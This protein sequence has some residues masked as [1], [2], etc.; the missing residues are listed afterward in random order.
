MWLT[1]WMYNGTVVM[2][3]GVKRGLLVPSV[4]WNEN[5]VSGKTEN[6]CKWWIPFAACLP[7]PSSCSL[8]WPRCRPYSLLWEMEASFCLEWGSFSLVFCKYCIPFP[9]ILLSPLVF[10]LLWTWPA[11]PSGSPGG[12]D[13]KESAFRRLRFDQEDPL[14][15]ERATHSRILAWR[16]PWAESLVGCS[17]WGCKELN[18]TEWLTLSFS[19]IPYFVVCGTLSLC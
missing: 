19:A 8:C 1:G 10:F 14:E 17:P 9:P 4:P 18:T 15:K 7:A 11:I 6:Y 13:N 16:T 12:S 5:H 3:H 2:P